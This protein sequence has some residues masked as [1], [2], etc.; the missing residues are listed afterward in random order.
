MKSPQAALLACCALLAM[1]A[2]SCTMPENNGPQVR[3][4][5]PPIVQTETGGRPMLQDQSNGLE[6]ITTGIG[7]IGG[8]IEKKN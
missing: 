2:T 5:Y 4:S 1:T 3:D 6:N 8:S 7:G